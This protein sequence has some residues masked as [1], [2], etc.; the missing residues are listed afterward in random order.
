[1]WKIFTDTLWG[2]VVA[3]LVLGTAL[4]LLANALRP[5]GAIPF[6]QDWGHYVEAKALEA[7]IGIVDTEQTQQRLN[8]GRAMILDARPEEEFREGRLPGA[9]SVPYNEIESAFEQVQLFFTPET[10]IITYCSGQACDDSFMLSRFLQEQGYT[11]VFIYAGGF[12]AWE[13]ADLP[14]E[15][16]P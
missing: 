10:E 2:R 8:D 1:M 12:K 9:M 16:R 6:V 14:V 3:L 7:G 5:A 15:G 11:N 13:D 4:G